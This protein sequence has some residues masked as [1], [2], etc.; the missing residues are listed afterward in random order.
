[1]TPLCKRELGGRNPEK[2]GKEVNTNQEKRG[3]EE[4]SPRW[5]QAGETGTKFTTLHN[6]LQ[7]KKGQSIG[8]QPK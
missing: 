5:W 7:S 4:K 2:M 8:S 3:R 1:M 6:I